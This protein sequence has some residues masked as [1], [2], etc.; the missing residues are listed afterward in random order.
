MQKIK[1]KGKRK[2][3]MHGRNGETYKFRMLEIIVELTAGRGETQ[4][5]TQPN[6]DL[7]RMWLS[8]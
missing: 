5:K 7:E 4:K 3:A 8:W 2:R 1:E 6:L